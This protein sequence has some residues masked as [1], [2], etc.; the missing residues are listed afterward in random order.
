MHA[1]ERMDLDPIP[2]RPGLAARVAATLVATPGW[3]AVSQSGRAYSPRRRMRAS[4]VGSFSAAQVYRVS[5]IAASLLAGMATAGSCSFS[6]LRK[7]YC[8]GYGQGVL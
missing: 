3:W 5:K 8:N 4:S 6:S 2:Q 7:E 1:I